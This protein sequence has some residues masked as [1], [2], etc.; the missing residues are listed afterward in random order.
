MVYSVQCC[1]RHGEHSSEH[2]QSVSKKLSWGGQL[3]GAAPP[4]APPTGCQQWGYHMWILSSRT[5]G[6]DIRITC[7]TSLAYVTID[8][9]MV[10]Q[11]GNKYFFRS[12]T[13]IQ[14]IER[15]RQFS[16][17]NVSWIERFQYIF[18]DW[19]LN[20]IGNF[21][22]SSVTAAPTLLWLFWFHWFLQLSWNFNFPRTRNGGR[23]RG[24][25]WFPLFA[26]Y[27]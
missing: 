23:C 16:K 12:F 2:R 13:Q 4:P 3:A 26:P 21:L 24:L 25:K 22:R 19:Q 10:K 17:F 27:W 15:I 11:A 5:L 14:I 9:I 20:H 8:Q 18:G 6:Q 7:H 1:T